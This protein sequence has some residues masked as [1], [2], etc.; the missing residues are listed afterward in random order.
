MLSKLN[1]LNSTTFR[2]SDSTLYVHFRVQSSLAAL[3]VDGLIVIDE[4]CRLHA[5]HMRVDGSNTR[6][7]ERLV[8]IARDD[9]ITFVG[10]A[11][12]RAVADETVM[13]TVAAAERVDA[14][15]ALI[16]V[17]CTELHS[18]L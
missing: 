11:A 10:A 12:L 18:L 3:V 2:G 5:A 6:P 4:D 15:E 13:Q 17:L 9:R 16:K 1:D 8:C 7:S 14:P